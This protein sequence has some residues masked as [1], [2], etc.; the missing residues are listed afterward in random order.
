[1]R[2]KLL[3]IIMTVIMSVSLFVGCTLFSDDVERDYLQ[4]VA[5]VESFTIKDE[6]T[7]KS[8]TSPETKIYKYELVSQ[9]NANGATLMNYYGINMEEIVEYM[10][11][12]LVTRKLIL[13]EAD[14][15]ISFNNIPWG[16]KQENEILEN[17]YYTI[18]SQLKAIG[19]EIRSEHGETV[20]ENTDNGAAEEDT[21]TTYP[22]PEVKEEGVYDN[23]TRDDLYDAIIAIENPTATAEQKAAL[24]E[25]LSELS[26]NKLISRLEN[27]EQQDVEPWT[28]DTI[29]Y[30][31]MYGTD[32]QKSL[33]IEAMRRFM[34]LLDETVEDDYRL[35]D[36]QRKTFRK[37]LDA[38]EKIGDEQGMSYV[39]PALGEKEII[40]FMIG[41]SY[42]ESVKISLLQAYIEDSAE[43]T[44][45]EVAAEY[46]NM[47]RKQKAKYDSDVESFYTDV[48]DGT[49]TILYYPN[50]DYYFVKHILVPF[51]DAQTAEL[52]NF[53]AV[54]GVL[55]GEAAIKAKKELL[56]R[57]VTGY[58]HRD[59]EDYGD[60]LTIAQIY[61]DIQAT[62]KA[63]SADMKSRDRAFESLIYK[64]N[65]DTGIFNKELGYAVKGKL[66]DG[67]DYDTTYM[68]EFS[69][70]AKELFEA[71]VE[72]AI[73]EPTVTDYGVHILYLSRIIPE[74]G[75][76]VGVNDYVSYGEHTNVYD[77]IES[78]RYTAKEERVFTAWQNQKIGYYLT[79]ADVVKYNEKAF[80]DL[81]ELE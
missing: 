42:R 41:Q 56:G 50:G 37:D 77:L 20:G 33:E 43:V 17:I 74:D 47:L 36:E 9:I 51:S 1:M 4:T 27:H 57:A 60:P 25:V 26:R 53:K 46:E 66:G 3:C 78:E 70:A 71:G 5:T 64:Y 32:D 63:A 29:R 15:E 44:E 11:D 39:Y 76:T 18:D 19:N 49:S 12:Q 21:E 2:K 16:T 45:S 23:W 72:G 13:A 67:E 80:E 31:G 7:G 22:T 8:Y 75:M 59:G 61:D 48:K 55:E 38:L 58:E 34:N 65:T 28:P 62:M 35:T 6:L 40:Q 68:Q 69:E 73:S 52:E 54:D 30:P 79:E 10:L 81:K 14:A 24:I